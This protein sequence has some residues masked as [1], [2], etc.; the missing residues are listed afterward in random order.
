MTG[1]GGQLFSKRIISSN[2]FLSLWK[3]NK[4]D[5]RSLHVGVIG[6]SFEMGQPKNGVA[7]SPQLII[8]E[9]NLLK[10]IENLG[11]TVDYRG[12][13]EHTT[14]KEVATGT[15][16]ALNRGNVH[17]F[18]KKLK[19][20]VADALK[21]N[22]FCITIGGDHSIG[23]GTVSGFTSV[24]PEGCLLWVDAH[25]DINTPHTSDSGN[26]HGMP[27]SYQLRELY[28]GF[29]DSDH[30]IDDWHKPRLSPERIAFI[31]LRSVD[32][33]EEKI[34]K[35][36]NIEAYFMNDIDELGIN[37]VI[38][39]SLQRINP[40]G[41]RPLHVSFDID[42]LDPLE[43]PATGTPVRGGLTLR[44]GLRILYECHKSG[45]LK[46]LD[47]VEVNSH[48]GNKEESLRTLTAAEHL[49]FSAFGHLLR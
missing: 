20:E 48:L 35:D 37:E 36:L 26:M 23:L 19:N 7:K 21:A 2:R 31:G 6:A 43:A 4:E 25:S 32:P 9:M 1:F 10:K 33:G 42:S 8:E 28:E 16:T 18:N 40:S 45:S 12:I 44:E 46:A 49:I 24:H 41:N 15:G 11:H 34:L 13:L 27:V 5:F 38:K 47:L 14:S 29:K 22:E 39:R 30:S 17:S 3:S